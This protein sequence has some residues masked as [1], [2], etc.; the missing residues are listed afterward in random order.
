ML[1]YSSYV[2]L[3]D[4][5]IASMHLGQGNTNTSGE[6]YLVDKTPLVTIGVGFRNLREQTG[7]IRRETD[8]VVV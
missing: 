3:C 4:T 2:K 8:F 7:A 1:R 6:I 5:L